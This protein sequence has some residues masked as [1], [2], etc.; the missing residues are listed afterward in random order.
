MA[1]ARTDL[2]ELQL[3]RKGLGALT[4]DRHACEDCGRTPL[5]GERVYLYGE[6]TLVCALCRPVHGG[7]PERTELVRH[8]EH[9][10]TV[11][12]LPAAA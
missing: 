6:E 12:R 10:R 9:E 2:L 4:R 1:R 5:P 8:T 7:E 3:L 11:R